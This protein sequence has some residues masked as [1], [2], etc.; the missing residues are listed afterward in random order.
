M[1]GVPPASA[2]RHPPRYLRRSLVVVSVLVLAIAAAC[3]SED[4]T[5]AGAV[6]APALEVGTVELPVA[7]D[8]RPMALRA[9]PGELLVVYFGYTAC[10]D[11][12]PTTM[13]DLSVAVHELP[14]AMVDKVAVAFATVDPDRDTAEVLDGYVGHFF[15]RGLGLRT[16]DPEQLA[17]AAA[18]FGVQYEVADHQPGDT[19]YEVAHTAVT[20]VIDDTGTVRV[21]WPFGFATDDMT[22]DLHILLT[23]EIS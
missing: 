1:D 16:E 18:A 15:E 2:G 19:S 4:E 20:Y 11:I 13:N 17:T 10:P 6:R 3:G 21:E 7:G 22:S 23:E 12:C 9:D 8:G 14:D 5:L